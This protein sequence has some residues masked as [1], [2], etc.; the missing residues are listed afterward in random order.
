[1]ASSGYAPRHYRT[2]NSLLRGRELVRVVKGNESHATNH[3]VRTKIEL[4]YCLDRGH[5]CGLCDR[6]A[7]KGARADK[8]C[9]GICQPRR[10]AMAGIHCQRIRVG[11]RKTASTWI[12]WL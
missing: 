1:M 4:E 9:R 8:D 6:V 3:Q 10:A 12:C 5:G 7:W 11:S 2:L